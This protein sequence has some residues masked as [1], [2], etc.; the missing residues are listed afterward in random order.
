MNE[1]GKR[2]TKVEPR[3]IRVHLNPGEKIVIRIE[4]NREGEI[5][6]VINP[7]TQPD[8][9]PHTSRE[10]ILL[11]RLKLFSDRIKT[12]NFFKYLLSPNGLF[13]IGFCLFLLT[14]FIRL[15]DFPVYFTSDEVLTALR[16]M[17]LVHSGGYD[18]EHHLLPALFLNF[19]RFSLGATVYFSIL[20][21]LLFGTS[22]W[23][24][25]ELPC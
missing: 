4:T 24:I 10:N 11:T 20:P 7:E 25:A 18:F 17:D 5:N 16:G 9:T 19:D 3:E 1:T 13:I 2:K 14:R 15:P 21:Q 6:P 22:V 8:P 12:G 23:V